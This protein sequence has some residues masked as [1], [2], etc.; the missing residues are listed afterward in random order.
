MTE[1][2]TLA[3]RCMCGAVHYTVADA[4]AYAV[5]RASCRVGMLVG[6]E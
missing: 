4:F 5:G 1:P 3:G 2:K 6:K